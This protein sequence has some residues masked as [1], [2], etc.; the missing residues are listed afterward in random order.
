MNLC[1]VVAMVHQTNLTIAFCC[2]F[3]IDYQLILG[4]F[5]Q[6]VAVNELGGVSLDLYKKCLKKTCQVQ[7]VNSPPRTVVNTSLIALKLTLFCSVTI[8]SYYFWPTHYDWAGWGKFQKVN[9]QGNG[10]ITCSLMKR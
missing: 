5:A 7:K 2:N 4:G 10:Y 3:S 1:R 9:W 8:Q 6:Y